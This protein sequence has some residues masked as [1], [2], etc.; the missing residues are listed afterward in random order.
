MKSAERKLVGVVSAHL[1]RDVGSWN[2][3]GGDWGEE[4]FAVSIVELV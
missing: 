1:N 2:Y 4:D 3:G